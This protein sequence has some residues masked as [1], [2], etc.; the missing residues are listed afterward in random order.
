M[1]VRLESSLTRSTDYSALCRF[2]WVS[3]DKG[4]RLSQSQVLYHEGHEEHEGVKEQSA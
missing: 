4:S 3:K 1:V 2:K